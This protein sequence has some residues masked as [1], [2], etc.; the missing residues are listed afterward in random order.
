MEDERALVADV[1]AH[2]PR[3]FERFVERYQRLVWHLV[4]RMVH[5]QEDT[6]ELAQDVFMRA[7]R[8]LPEFRFESALST[9]LGQIAFSVAGRH[10]QKK[11]IAIV[12]WH[13]EEGVDRIAE[14]V[15]DEF[16]LEAAV[17]SA[18]LGE[19]VGRALQSLPALQRTLVSL[20]YLEELSVGEIATMAGIPEGTAKSYLFRARAQLR[21]LL[22][23]EMGMAA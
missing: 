8:Y 15:G 16:D 11:R 9:W 7:H 13:D 5:S 21:A 19:R 1:L 23:T 17:I 6:E 22:S 4:G 20:Y 2:K 12:D 14:T 18:D 3:A 10:L